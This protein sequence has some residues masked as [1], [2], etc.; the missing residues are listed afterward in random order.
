M[1]VEITKQLEKAVARLNKRFASFTYKN[2]RAGLKL[3]PAYRE[4]DYIWDSLYFVTPK[5]RGRKFVGCS[6]AA[7]LSEKST[8]D[9]CRR[10][11]HPDL[12]HL[13]LPFLCKFSTGPSTSFLWPGLLLLLA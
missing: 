10:D 3:T 6:R 12:L 4:A 13:D 2:R 7:F 5:P 11:G 1:L 9:F 8:F